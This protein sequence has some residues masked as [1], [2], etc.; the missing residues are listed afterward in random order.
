MLGIFITAAYPSLESSVKAL[1]VLHEEKVSLIE[2]GIPFS[3]PLADGPVI[4]NASFQALKNG[5]NIDGIFSLIE[6]ARAELNLSLVSSSIVT[7][8]QIGRAH[9]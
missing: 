5:I 4:Q 8:K 6:Q 1:K 7:G 2:L 3:D 9:V